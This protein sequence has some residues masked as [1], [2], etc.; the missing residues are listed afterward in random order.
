LYPEADPDRRYSIADIDAL[1]A[2]H[3]C[4]TP[5]SRTSFLQF[6]RRFFLISTYLC[7]KD[8]ISAHEQSCAFVR[9]IPT[10]ISSRVLERLR[11]RCPD[12]H[13]HD[14]YPLPDLRDAVDFVLLDSASILLR[15]SH[16]SPAASVP[17]PPEPP[18]SA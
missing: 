1:V 2:E 16:A 3:S 11:I 14:P 15:T 12:V 4:I 17:A 5:P 6:S 18:A 7:A 8:R 10:S 13:P 9:A